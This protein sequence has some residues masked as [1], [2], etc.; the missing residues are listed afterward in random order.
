V[1]P[2]K[3]TEALSHIGGVPF[4]AR[5]GNGVIYYRGGPEPPQQDLPVVLTRRIKDAYDPK[6]VLAEFTT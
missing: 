5:A 2:S 3:I 1:L 6:H 4:V